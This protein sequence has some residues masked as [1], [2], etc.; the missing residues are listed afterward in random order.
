M[1]VSTRWLLALPLL[2]VIP[3]ASADETVTLDTVEVFGKPPAD[4]RLTRTTTVTSYNGTLLET[5]GIDT[6]TELAPLVPGLF[7][8]EQS[9]VTT[10][11][12]LRGV[13]T[14]DTDPR[15]TQRVAAFQD[16][17]FLASAAGQN[18]ALFDLERI[19][20]LK[21]PQPVTF[22]RAA[23][24]GAIQTVTHKADSTKSTELTA[25]FGDYNSRTA[26]GFTNLPIIDGKLFAR[27]AFTFDKAD[28]Y[29]DNLADG[30]TLQGRD[31]TAF[32]G[33]L[34]WQPSSATTAD[35]IFNYQ[36]DTPPGTAFKSMVIP[37]SA[38]DTNPYTAADLNRGRALG[39][40]REIF[41][42][43]GLVTHT[44]NE[45]WTLAS[46]TG[47]RDID[48][49]E[50]FDADGSF[51][52]ALDV[53]DYHRARQFSQDFCLTYDSGDRLTASIGAGAFWQKGSQAAT[54]TSD[55]NTL[56]R[57]LT[58]GGTPPFPL[59]T[60]YEENYT[61]YGET[62]S[63]DVFGDVNYKLTRRFTVG[64]NLRVTE[65]KSTSGYRS[66]PTTTPTTPVFIPILPT[67]GGNN[68]FFAPTAGLIEADDHATSWVGGIN[69]NYEITPQ[70]NA[71]ASIS[72]GRRPP[73]TTFSQK[74][75]FAPISLEEEVVWNY[76]TGVKGYLANR[77]ITYGI[78]AFLY[79]YNHFQTNQVTSLG[80]TTPTDGGRARGQGFETTLQGAVNDHLL[81]FGSYG[82]TDAKF[83]ALD[84][85]GNPQAYAG[86]TFR[87]T[88]RHTLTV[89]ATF[90]MPVDNVGTFFVTPIW[91]Y[92][93][94]QFFEDDNANT[95]TTALN[96]AVPLYSLRQGGYGLLNLRT[97]FRTPDNRWEVV[98]WVR[99]LL[100][101][102]YLIDAG[103][104]GANFGFPTSVRGAPRTLGV[105]VTARF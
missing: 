29:V 37:T 103:N 42:I 33:S 73:S 81:L 62:L 79:D 83:A 104:I 14:D 45:N 68:S 53:C 8:S 31:T 40:D 67:A 86:N 74:P 52:P 99:N 19:D 10:S 15:V 71:Y 38:G 97:G 12:N 28:G 98:L 70:H 35:L 11:Y 101:K 78:A 69:A 59:P 47:W 18:L 51:E 48:A 4:L 46:T 17:V 39:I 2:S 23:Q 72:R 41:A 93:S 92:K 30:S 32:R 3:A 6:Y 88:A 43:T 100:D 27:A 16:G 56:F 55:L 66:L 26:S 84:E 49:R 22:G 63:G 89:G 50:E 57:L 94:E 95:G 21:G 58:G 90:T 64:A 54:V 76:E 61:K 36:H 91:E 5:A 77:R 82:F 65:E 85:D 102:D 87:L 20:V 60:A 7:I 24:I 34:R 1:R 9:V 13:T 44:L 25:G 96:P 75:P 80:T 105:Q